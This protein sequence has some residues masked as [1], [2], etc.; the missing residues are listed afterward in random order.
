MIRRRPAPIDTEKTCFLLRGALSPDECAGLATTAWTHGLLAM[1][2]DYPPDYRNND[3]ALIDDAAMAEWLFERLRAWLP[4]HV[5]LA[6]ETWT[7]VGLNP[8]F[9]VCRYRDGQRFARHRDGAWAPHP[10]VRSL[11]TGML[12]LDDSAAFTGGMTRFF[13]GS[14]P[15]AECIGEVLPEAGTMIV[16]DH[17]LWHDGAPVTRG[18]KQVL[19]TDVLYERAMP[20]PQAHRSYIWSLVARG[21]GTLASGSRDCTIR[22]WRGGESLETWTAHTA[23]VTALAEASDGALWSGSRDRTVRRW[24]DGVSVV[25][26]VA[27]GAVLALARAGSAV[28]VADSTGTITRLEHLTPVAWQAHVGWVWGLGELP[29]GRL[30]SGG[31]DGAV[32]IWR[33]DGQRERYVGLGAP[34]RA[35]ATDGAVIV[36]GLANGE[37]VRLSL[38]LEEEARW[39]AHATP[40]TCVALGAGG[41]VASGGEDQWARV[42]RGSDEVGSCQH[43]DFVR[44]V[45]CLPSGAVV[46]AGYD[47]VLRTMAS[48]ARA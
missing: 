17:T 47:G 46:S 37:L 38:T 4:S 35:L 18:T 40:V 43:H 9:R 20:D 22:L 14:E 33:P 39:Q 29:G 31:E 26:H 2:S 25:R 41:C 36:A 28:A 21:D 13:A 42:W 48:T 32:A 1:A 3:R 15:T 5:E 11:L 6:G 19:R 7:L 45:A 44:A 30:V 16:F 10:G 23:S 12:Y 8:R 24:S 34:V 27:G